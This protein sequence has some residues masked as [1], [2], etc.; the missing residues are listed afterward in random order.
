VT[1][2]QQGVRTIAR[3]HAAVAAE[4]FADNARLLAS[5]VEGDWTRPTGCAQWDLRRLEGHLLGEAVWFAHLPLEAGK[6]EKPYPNS[7][8]AELAALPGAKMSKRMAQAA[9]ELTQ[10]VDALTSDELERSADLGWV[11]RPL[12]RA[13]FVGVTEAVYHNWDARAA[14]DGEATVPTSWAVHLADGLEGQ[15]SVLVHRDALP[16]ARGEYL[17]LVG[18]GVGPRTITATAEEV[19]IAQGATERP[20]VTISLSADGYVRL[21]AGRYPL[22]TELAE[23]RIQVDG[24][25]S[26]L[27]ALNRIYAGIAND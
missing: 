27:S 6:G 11:R 19:S 21:L 4:A 10:N 8:W 9:D 24:D 12:Y 20:D 15:A 1:T 16:G 13:L 26:R 2:D 25:V 17:L 22:E 18:D 14:F 5:L 23:G 7:L 3:G